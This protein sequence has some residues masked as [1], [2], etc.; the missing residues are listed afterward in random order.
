[1]DYAYF[2]YL[3]D[4]S[5]GPQFWKPC[6]Y[7]TCTLPKGGDSGDYGVGVGCDSGGG[8][9]CGLV[10]VE[11]VMIVLVL[12]VL[13]IGV[14]VATTQNHQP[15]HHCPHHHHHKSN[16]KDFYIKYFFLQNIKPSLLAYF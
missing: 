9:H 5:G 12:V 14:L 6:L 15:H 2:A 7:N 10:M 3:G 4:G 1:M 8:G 16:F 13:K 11:V